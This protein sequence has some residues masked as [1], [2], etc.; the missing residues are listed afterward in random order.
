MKRLG[1]N[2]EKKIIALE[3]KIAKLSKKGKEQTQKR[4]TRVRARKK[5]LQSG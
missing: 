5:Y 3:G 1:S 2:E 4:A